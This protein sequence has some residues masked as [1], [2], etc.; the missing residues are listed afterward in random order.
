[1]CG[2][3]QVSCYPTGITDHKAGPT[4]PPSPGPGPSNV[5]RTLQNIEYAAFHSV[6]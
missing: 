4:P 6:L 1:M 3:G 2:I 5:R